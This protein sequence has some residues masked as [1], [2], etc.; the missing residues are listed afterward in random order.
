M[1]S[2]TTLPAKFLGSAHR[3][4]STSSSPNDAASA[5]IPDDAFP[6]SCL[7]EYDIFWRLPATCLPFA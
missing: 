7:D 3:V 2:I 4:A 1:I 5:N 6:L